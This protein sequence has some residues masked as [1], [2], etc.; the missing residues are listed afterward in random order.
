MIRDCDTETRGR[1]MLR[2]DGNDTH[3]GE[4]I[5][6]AVIVGAGPNGLTAGAV[7]ARAGLSVLVLEAASTPGGGCRTAELTLPGFHH[8]VCA[9][10]HPMGVVSPAFRE[11][12]LEQ[13][14][15]QWVSAPAPLAHPLDDR[16]ILLRGSLEQTA[17]GLG[18]DAAA[19]KRLLQ[20]FVARAEDFFHETLRPIRFP[21]APML[22]ARF[23][24]GAL[25]SSC[26]LAGSRFSGASA[27]ALFTG[28]GAHAVVT[29]DQTGSA[30]FA[31][32]LAVAGHAAGWPC[33]RGGSA[34]IIRALQTCLE[35]AGGRVQTGTAVRRMEDIPP[36]RAVL[37]DLTPRQVADIAETALP[38]AYVSRLRKFR[39]GAGAFKVDWAL[40]GPIPWRWP[41]CLQAGTVHVGGTDG[42][43][44]RAE[45]EV[46]DGR[47]PER[48]FVL[49]AQQTLFDGTRAPEGKHTGWAYCHV[50][51]GCGVDMTGRIESQIERFAPGFRD[52]ILGRFSRGPA[53]Y[54][55]YNANMIGGDIGGGSN[56]LLQLLFRPVARYDPYST[57][58]PRL[59][60]CSSSTPPG[61]G[62]HGMCGYW[63]ARSA[64]RRVFGASHPSS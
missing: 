36:S 38:A 56:D 41:E 46:G 43:I 39:Y 40:S 24:L 51:A 61:G 2:S 25:R 9:A 50:P 30:A 1:V 16:A 6:D 7:L 19:W 58:N 21:G 49:V 28:C 53:D 13:H 54:E 44:L 60:I 33:A 12:R 37:F 34:R 26:A 4:D 31:L 20:P 57:P 10:I 29:P 64:L 35:D 23:A 22:M 52:R 3:M 45:R 62:V 63:A 17:A 48:P 47:V 32:V 55:A 27:K 42:E 11:L 59:F 15:L 14:G 18:S 5:Y 8:D